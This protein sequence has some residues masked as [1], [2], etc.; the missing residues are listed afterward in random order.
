M[1]WDDYHLHCFR[2][3][4]MRYGTADDEDVDLEEIDETTVTIAEAFGNSHRGFYDYDF[5]DSREHELLVEKLDPLA[6]L[7]P[8][9]VCVDGK[10]AFLRRTAMGSRAMA[11]SSRPSPIQRMKRT[12]SISSGSAKTSIPKTSI[13]KR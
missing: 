5:G 9:A 13:P 2:I 11:S 6:I 7:L 3:G 4:G 12:R 1:G 8:L 10:R